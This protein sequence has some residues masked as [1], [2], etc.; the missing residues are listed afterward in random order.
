MANSLLKRSECRGPSALAA[1]LSR[2]WFPKAAQT[3]S[4]AAPW[5]RVG[6]IEMKLNLARAGLAGG[7]GPQGRG[8]S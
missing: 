7:D 1:T 4:H 6:Q 3:A 5:Q 2:I 8:K